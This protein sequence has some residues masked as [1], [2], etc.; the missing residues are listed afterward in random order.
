[1]TETIE[2]VD[3]SRAERL[4][5]GPQAGVSQRIRVAEG[6]AFIGLLAAFMGALGPA[7]R[8]STVYSWPPS[9]V[10]DAQPSRMWYTP[11]LLV[12]QRH[13]ETIS[14]TLP[15]SATPAQP[16]ASSPVIVFATVRFPERVSGLF[17]TRDSTRL[18]VRIGPTL[19][20]RAPLSARTTAA[21]DCSYHLLFDDGRWS[22]S[23]G[24]GDISLAGDVGLMPVV[25]GL[26]SELDLRSPASLS[27]AVTTKPH[28]TRAKVHQTVGWVVAALAIGASLWLIAFERRPRRLWRRAR[29][30]GRQAA[31]HAHPADAVVAA[32]LVVWW[33]F[34]P[35]HWDDGWAIARQ[36]GFST[37]GGF[38]N[39]YDSFGANLPNGYWIDWLQHWL[40]QHSNALLVLRIPALVCLAATWLLS[41]WILARILG[42]SRTVDGLAL[43]AFTSAFLAGALAWGMTLRP[44]PVT[45]LLIAAVMACVVWFVDR[46]TAAPLALAAILV[47]LA[48][49]AHHAG[50]ATIAPLLIIAPRL[51]TWIRANRAA[52]IALAIAVVGLSLALAFVGSDLGQRS[53][54]AAAIRAYAVPDAWFDELRRYARL[55][56][57]HGGPP[58]RRASFALM[59]LAVLAFLV[60][61]R[62]E[63]QGLVDL[64]APALGVMLLLLLAAPSKWPWHFG[65]FIGVASLAV[66]AETH[67]LGR[68]AV[69][70]SGWQARP[71]VV[72]GA[73][74]V[75]IAWAWGPRQPWTVL[76]LR[77]LDWRLG[78]EQALSLSAVAAGL[79]IVLVGLLVAANIRRAR[80]RTEAPW[81]V[82]CATAPLLVVPIVVFTLAALTFDAATS[83]WTQGR[84]NLA[85]F[86]GSAGC[87]LAD[88]LLTPSPVSMSPLAAA[89]STRRPTVPDWVPD[90]PIRAIP[91][92]ALG[93]LGVEVG[94]VSSPWFELPRASPARRVGFFAAG[95]PEAA[96]RLELEWGRSTDDGFE[97]LG[98]G[99]VGVDPRAETSGTSPWRFVASSDLPQRGPEANAAR[100]TLHSGVRPGSLVAVTSLVAYSNRSFGQLLARREGQTW[101]SPIVAPYIPCAVLPALRDGVAD[102]PMYVISAFAVRDLPLGYATSPFNGISDVYELERITFADS[103]N[104]PRDDLGIFR[105]HDRILGAELLRPDKTTVV[106]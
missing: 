6:L 42:P 86:R 82:A 91:R 97:P 53:V 98:G 101:V 19:L 60:R 93:P 47:S 84:Q 18:T 79:P 74:V 89:N 22:L 52:A 68:Q 49:T 39:Y 92:F 90:A 59:A 95:D 11:L 34:S 13:P 61:R 88:G 56:D 80:R 100:I 66:A 8:V 12:A 87:G 104:A 5:S 54:D 44:E 62:R 83:P 21:D 57:F 26:F 3:E 78:F 30:L 63:R 4:E 17:V 20:T 102:V 55:S 105:V 106:S 27:A 32:T 7:D 25:S 41:R 24:P 31:A 35:A 1:M 15:C 76:D 75:A 85:V 96:G 81:R 99:L 51:L 58:L 48:V 43:W 36:R 71:F 70:S 29:R 50:I 45:A 28:K 14:A 67:R 40:V 46:E 10:P 77:A 94:S 9:A 23:G 103:D 72:V 38:S 65:A 73:A 64:P 33:V 16:T 2:G 69:G 37:S